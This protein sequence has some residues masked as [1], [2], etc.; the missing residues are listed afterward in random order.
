M[1]E[2]AEEYVPA[3]ATAALFDQRVHL[4]HADAST[5]I[6]AADAPYDVVIMQL[7]DPG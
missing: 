4:F 3:P 7:G 5:F 6:R 1:L 2:L